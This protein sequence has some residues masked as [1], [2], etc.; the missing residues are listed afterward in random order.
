MKGFQRLR[1]KLEGLIFTIRAI[2][3]GLASKTVLEDKSTIS[4]YKVTI[5]AV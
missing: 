2:V 5:R 3:L 1:C 4:A